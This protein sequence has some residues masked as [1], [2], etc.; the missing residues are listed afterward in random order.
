M[1][2]PPSPVASC[3]ASNRGTNTKHRIRHFFIIESS[4]SDLL[5]K[6]RFGGLRVKK[7]VHHPQATLDEIGGCY[8]HPYKILKKKE[9]QWSI[10]I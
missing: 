8:N 3:A 10:V 9:V 6:V 2:L 7:Y 1:G 5:K 4:L